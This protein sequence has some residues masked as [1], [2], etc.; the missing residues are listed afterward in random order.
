MIT[1]PAEKI[2]IRKTRTCQKCKA[3][4]P[5]DKVRLFPKEDNTTLLLCEVCC[6]DLKSKVM[7]KNPNLGTKVKP[8]G[9]ADYVIYF[10][11]RCK[12]RFRVDENKAGYTC[13]LCCPYCGKNDRLNVHR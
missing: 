7:T 12:Y 8:L 3:S 13:N 1:N 4:V 10:C 2:D 9:K 6:A 5:L 11:D